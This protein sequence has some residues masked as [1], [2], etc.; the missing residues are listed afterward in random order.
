MPLD[1]STKRHVEISREAIRNLISH[2]ATDDRLMVVVGPC[3]IHDTNAALEYA[4]LLAQA[5]ERH[6]RE[7]VIVMR[8]YIEKPR[9]T[10]GWKGLIHDPDYAQDLGHS[11]KTTTPD[12]TK[13]VSTARKVMLEVAKMGLPVATELLNPLLVYF[14]DDIV[15]LGVI[16]ARTTES[17][18]H[19]EMAS[20]MPMPMGIKNGTDGSLKVAIDAM[21]AASRPHTVVG[22]DEDASLAYHIS[23]G[24]PDTF[25]ILRGGSKGPNYSPEHIRAAEA[26]LINAG[27]KAALVVDCSH[28]NSS[29]DYRNQGS[30]AACLADQIAVGAPIMGVMIESNINE[31]RQDVPEKGSKACL[32][33]GVSITDGCV[34]WN[35]TES[36]LENLAAAVRQRQQAS[37]GSSPVEK[38]PPT[39]MVGQSLGD[40]KHGIQER[41]VE[42]FI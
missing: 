2:H 8:V 40:E 13:G 22:V 6:R 24:N 36:I 14:L 23:R 17:Q 25:V 9:S 30:V 18:T 7:L 38:S 15:S 42:V 1:E 21:K 41:A 3:S 20:D 10:V 31:G 11:N 39:I 34:G 26:E 28:G 32:K 4:S 19:R 29:K 35:E 27:K 5:A 16:G 37:S 33:Y 12:L